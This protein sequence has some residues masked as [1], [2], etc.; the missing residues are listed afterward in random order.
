MDALR[1]G[2]RALEETSRAEASVPAP[3]PTDDLV[4]APHPVLRAPARDGAALS[5]RL[6]SGGPDDATAF[7]LRAT[8]ALDLAPVPARAGAFFE[9]HAAALAHGDDVDLVVGFPLVSF[10]QSGQRRTAPLLSWSGAR[11]LWR[12][13]DGPWAL[14]RGAR[15]GVSVDVPTSLVLRAP[16]VDDDEAAVTLHAGLWR[17]L[18]DV[19]GPAL[20]ALAQAGRASVGALVRAATQTLTRGADESPD[21]SLDDAPPTRDE[22]RALVDAVRARASSRSSLQAHPH[23]LAMLLPLGDP[24]SGLRTELASLLDRNAPKKGPLAVFLGLRPA[25]ERSAPLWT[26]GASTPTP[27]QVAAASALEGSS[28]LV[29]LCGPPGCGKTTLLHHVAAQAIVARALDDTWVKPPGVAPPWGLVVASTNNAAVDHA[30]AP[31]VA[32]RA[33]PVG[34]RLGNRRTLFEATAQGLRAAIDALSGNDGPSWPQ[35]R[36]AFLERSLPVREYLRADAERRPAEERRERERERLRSRADE[37]RHELR[38]P[39]IDVDDELLPARVHDVRGALQAHAHAATL[40]VPTHLAGGNASAE[41][42]RRKWKTA[43]TQRAKVIAPLLAKLGMAA[44]YR[45]LHEGEDIAAAL[46]GQHAAMLRTL[47]ALEDVER[48]LRAPAHRRELDRVEASLE[49]VRRV[50]P[51]VAP[52]PRDPSLVEAALAMRDAWARTHREVLV[53]RLEAALA[54]VTEEK[55]PARGKGLVELL[56]SLSGLFPVVGCTLLSLRGCV[57]LEEGAIDRLVIDEAGQCAPVYTV[58]ALAR[59]RRAMVTGDV[60]QLPPVYTLDDRADARLARELDDA[61]TEPFRMGASATTSAQAVAERR[62]ASPRSLVEH[63]RSQPEIVALASAWSGYSLDVRTPPRSLS[64]VSPR[65]SRAVQ[66]IDVRG[67][68]VRAPEGVVN[69]A[70]AA[71]VVA[72]VAALVADGVAARDVAAL[73]PFVGQ[74]TRIERELAR[75]GLAGEGGVLVRTVHKLQGGERR[76]VVFSVTATEAKHL[77]WLATRPHLLHVATSRAQDHLAVFMD[78]ER[79]RGEALL[80]PLVE[81][82]RRG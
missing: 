48:S 65:L 34:L 8:D 13:G 61:A 54:L 18:L 69:E 49:E 1:Y 46:A 17:Q 35:A 73:T 55:F 41:R 82:A 40:V 26:H 75:A 28:D 71:R 11:A 3:A 38:A 32:S 24:T 5:L 6:F 22:L 59:A 68:G 56:G 19:D 52:P 57:A 14:P 78:A 76:V 80:R 2:L 47:E 70:E 51:E 79:A 43:N 39:L 74:S 4:F 10:T 15:P 7:V 12:L 81:L 67:R 58:A 27:S 21:E 53:P 44:P 45:D 29:A 64:Q 37:L 62:A 36:A 77:R 66:V 31:F 42:A 9:A 16:E 25:P 60:A 20:S 50:A 72:L 33:L 63:F 23:G 30:L